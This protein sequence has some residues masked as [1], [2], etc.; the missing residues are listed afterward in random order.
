[1]H[2]ANILPR[3]DDRVDILEHQ[4]VNLGDCVGAG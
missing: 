2:V 3:K 1:M 4:E